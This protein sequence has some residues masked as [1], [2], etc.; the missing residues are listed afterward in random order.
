MRLPPANYTARDYQA[1]AIENV[2]QAYQEGHIGALV[3]MPTGTGKTLVGA[4]I[5]KRWCEQGPN[6][7][8]MVSAH[9]KQLVWQFH[10]HLEEI[11]GEKPGLEMASHGRVDAENVPP[12]VVVS[13]ATLLPRA[14]QNGEAP[15]SRLWKFDWKLNWLLII[16]EVHR[17]KFG[18]KASRHLL[19]YLEQNPNHRRL[20]LTATPIRGDKVSLK[21]IT[22]SIALD[23]RLFAAKGQRSAVDDGWAVPYDQ[24]FVQVEGVDWRNIREVAKDFDESEL[25]MILSQRERL[26]SLIQPTLDLAE[27]RSTLIF[28]PTRDMAR[29]VAATINAELHQPEAARHLDGTFPDHIRRATYRDHQQ[30]KFQFLSVCGLCREGYNDPGIACVAVFRPTKSRGLAEQMKGRGCRPLQGLVDKINSPEDRKLAIKYSAKPDCRIIDLVGITG[31]AD[32]VSTAHIMAEGEPDEV[33]D[34]ANQILLTTEKTDV[35]EALAEAKEEAR[36][37]A[38]IARERQD[39]FDRARAE[40]EAKIQVDVFYQQRQV[41]QGHFN[42]APTYKR[43]R[44][45]PFGKF[46]GREINRLPVWYL[47]WLAQLPD[48]KGICNQARDILYRR[49]KIRYGPMKGGR[50]RRTAGTNLKAQA[51]KSLSRY[52]DI[53]RKFQEALQS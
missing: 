48:E 21:R 35:A 47:K 43:Y 16:D 4:L 7:H 40:R 8:A 42:R 28:S 24:R 33:V 10:D 18:G 30:R 52:D 31:L 25:G 23:Y 29:M 38:E 36:K 34:A 13:R 41:E 14:R 6:Y 2:F 53:N 5:A 1:E 44:I 39:A 11:L 12:I 27:D 37:K 50:K 46:K 26:L 20:G 19:E 49:T 15:V 22:P 32:C 51:K 45:M 9:E 3:R 17:Y